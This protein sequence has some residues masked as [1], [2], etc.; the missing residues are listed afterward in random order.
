[1]SLQTLGTTETVIYNDIK[2]LT[3]KSKY[4]YSLAQGG[5]GLL[6]Q[7]SIEG[8][9]STLSEAWDK[10]NDPNIPEKHK[11]AYLRLTKEC[12]VW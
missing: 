11:V 3:K 1:M 6:Y 2:F 12:N 7:K 9:N 10:F 8:I 5:H 4:L